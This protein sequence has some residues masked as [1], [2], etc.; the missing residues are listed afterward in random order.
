MGRLAVLQEV[1][2]MRFENVYGRYFGGRLKC[3]EAAELLGVGKKGK[4]ILFNSGANKIEAKVS[5]SR[6]KVMIGG[7]E[8][9][10]KKLKTGMLCTIEYAP[11][12]DNE[13]KLV[14]CG[15]ATN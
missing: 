6:S 13:P 5:G 14:D 9:D 8:D 2:I 7:N 10:R 12:G 15:V 11:G 1:R 3:E 4:T